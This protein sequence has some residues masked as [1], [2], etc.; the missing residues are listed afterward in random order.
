[1]EIKTHQIG[2]I[3]IAEIISAEIIIQNISDGLDLVGNVYYQEFDSVILQQHHLVPEFFDLK[4]GMAGEIL[5]K[6]SNYKL[7][8]A[9]VGDFSSLTSK[10]IRDFIYESNH[11]GHINFLGSVEE[12]LEVHSSK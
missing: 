5:Q 12:A 2:N 11:V 10:S 9:I 7:R 8:L 6:F 3:K 4:N 1:M